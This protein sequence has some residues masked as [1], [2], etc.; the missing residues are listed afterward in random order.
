MISALGTIVWPRAAIAM[1]PHGA[2]AVTIHIGPSD[3]W[4]PDPSVCTSQSGFCLIALA[5]ASP[6][7]SRQIER[8]PE[9]IAD[10]WCRSLRS[11]CDAPPGLRQIGWRLTPRH[12]NRLWTLELLDPRTIGPLDYRT[13]GPLGPQTIGPSEYRSDTKP[14]VLGANTSRNVKLYTFDT[15]MH[16]TNM[17]IAL[18]R[19]VA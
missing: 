1:L 14:F 19:S 8:V 2:R 4:D 3:Y 11:R 17:T 5:G 9:G 7:T 12:L 16:K 6:C 15:L 13:L 10:P 18:P